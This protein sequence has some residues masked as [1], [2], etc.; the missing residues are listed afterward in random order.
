MTPLKPFVSRKQIKRKSSNEKY[1][2]LKEVE[3]LKHS[4]P[5][6]GLKLNLIDMSKDYSR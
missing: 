2:E 1:N 3:W 6:E 4:N 5:N